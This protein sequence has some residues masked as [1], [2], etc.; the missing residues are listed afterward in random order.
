MKQFFIVDSMTISPQIIYYHPH[1]LASDQ[2]QALNMLLKFTDHIL[3]CFDDN[4][5]GIATFIYLSK[6]FDCVDHK[7]L[8]TKISDMVSIQHLYDG[9]VVTFQTRNFLYPGIRSIPHH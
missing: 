2:E 1:N 3:K 6:A 9:S 7:I 8:L 5:V 4:K